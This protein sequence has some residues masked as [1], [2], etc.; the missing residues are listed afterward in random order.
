[1]GQAPSTW[2][3]TQMRATQTAA[4]PERVTIKRPVLETDT[5]GGVN[6]VTPVVIAEDVPAR[7]T[8][9]Q[10]QVTLGQAGRALGLEKW[11]IRMPYGTTLADEDLVEWGGHT[12]TV[13]DVKARDWATTLSAK[14]E[15]VK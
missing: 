7:I 8:Q 12:L 10:V 6:R 5:F 4:M 11:T 15:I 3:L 2:E 1:M 13:E 14:A 9:A